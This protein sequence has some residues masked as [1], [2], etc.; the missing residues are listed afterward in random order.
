MSK[1]GS[2]LM[3]SLLLMPAVLAPLATTNPF[4]LSQEGYLDACRNLEPGWSSETI[5]QSRPLSPISLCENS[6]NDLYI[7]DREA[8]EIVEL[9]L[10]GSV[11]GLFRS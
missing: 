11:S 1:V 6:T 9:E 10:D 2:M 4:F 8:H 7:L 3:I 5:Y